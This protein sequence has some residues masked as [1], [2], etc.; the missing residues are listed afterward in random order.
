[1]K[2]ENEVTVEIN[3]ELNELKKYL[4]NLGFQEKEEYDLN[5]IYMVNK[6]IEHN[7][8][9]L[10]ILSNCILIRHIIEKD[11]EKKQVTYKYKEYNDNGDIVK[12]GK[13]D[14]SIDSIEQ[15][16]TLFECLRYEEIITLNDH[17]IVYSNDEDE[18]ALQIVNNKHIYIEV[19]ENCNFI[20]RHYND[21]EEMKNVFI[22]YNI[23][24]KN[25]DYFV[26][27]AAIEIKESLKDK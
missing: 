18:F 16:K 8:D 24:I 3:M 12:Q 13:A 7:N 14:C 2:F 10:T 21:I 11:K 6:N 15:A 17:L 1:M 22:K 23:P 20:D 4:S 9:P 27:K 19:E 26:K 5:D 25:D